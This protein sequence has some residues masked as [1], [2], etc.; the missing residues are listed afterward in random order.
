MVDKQCSHEKALV[1][2]LNMV[3]ERRSCT[4]IKPL[5]C[6]EGILRFGD[7]ELVVRLVDQSSSGYQVRVPGT[8]G[9][10]LGTPMLLF[11]N[12]TWT[13]V[14]LMR[15]ERLQSDTRL[16]LKREF[17]LPNEDDFDE[18]K[19]T[20]RSFFPR[21]RTT[22]VTVGLALGGLGLVF[23]LSVGMWL[24]K[25]FVESMRGTPKP[26]DMIASLIPRS[27]DSSESPVVYRPLPSTSN[28][29]N[30]QK[31]PT[32]MSTGTA[33]E[34]ADEARSLFHASLNAGERES[35]AMVMLELV[36][37]VCHE[38]TIN[39]LQLSRNQLASV[40]KI[41]LRGRTLLANRLSTPIDDETLREVRAIY[42]QVYSVLNSRQRQLLENMARKP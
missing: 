22:R 1:S 36:T 28:D 19:T 39:K 29:T 24:F 11:L 31:A 5:E 14:Q 6:V 18:L 13:E 26:G 30:S 20:W 34:F 8:H 33:A 35:E 12:G 23:F 7:R 9:F 21:F 15:I 17:D 3:H 41:V 40:Q 4:R 2:V 25:D 27:R 32:S 37:A 16:G 42:D 10:P 38:K